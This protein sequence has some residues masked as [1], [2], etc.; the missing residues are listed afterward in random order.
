M[1]TQ[2]ELYNTRRLLG[3]RDEDKA[4]EVDH[5]I[6]IEFDIAEAVGRRPRIVNIEHRL[7]RIS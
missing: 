4:P 1:I 6:E 7:G 2:D 3:V 5:A